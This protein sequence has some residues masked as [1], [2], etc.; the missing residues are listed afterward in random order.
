[1]EGREGI[2][3]YR[4][5]SRPLQHPMDTRLSTPLTVTEGRKV[6]TQEKREVFVVYVKTT[7]DLAGI[8]FDQGALLS[9]NGLC[10]NSQLIISI[11]A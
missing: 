2:D 10:H 11:I 5:P 8:G 9:L 4:G 3:G 7:P 6:K 1:M